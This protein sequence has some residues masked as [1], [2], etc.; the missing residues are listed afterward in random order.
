MFLIC[1]PYVKYLRGI[2]RAVCTELSFCF[3]EKSRKF[4]LL[5]QIRFDYAYLKS[6]ILTLNKQ[7]NKWDHHYSNQVIK[8]VDTDQFNS[9]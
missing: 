3:M 2:Y 6:N 7:L 5:F 8:L 1:S 9:K 4:P